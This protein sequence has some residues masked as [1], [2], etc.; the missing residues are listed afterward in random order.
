M[1]IKYH[2]NPDTMKPGVCKARSGNC[3]FKI[4]DDKHFSNIVEAREYIEKEL[5]EDNNVVSSLDKPVSK[6]ITLNNYSKIPLDVEDEE[7]ANAEVLRLESLVSEKNEDEVLETIT[8]RGLGDN[9]QKA[10][11]DRD[12]LY[13]LSKELGDKSKEVRE[14]V[15]KGTAS[16]VELRNAVRNQRDI[17]EHL[18]ALNNS[19]HQYR[20]VTARYAEAY[21]ELR[22]NRQRENGEFLTYEAET[23]GSLVADAEYE[24][25]SPEWHNQRQGGIGGSDVAK[26]MKVDEKYGQNEYNELLLKKV[27][28]NNSNDTDDFRNDY[29][30]AVG[31]G[32]AWEETIRHMY[33][34]RNPDKN[35]A[36]CKTSWEGAGAESYKHAN[37]DG[38]E[39]DEN[40]KPVGII[41]IK[42]GI[43]T[44]KWGS[45]DDGY[46]G[47]PENYRK[48]VLWYAANADLK[49]ATLVAVLDDYDYREY[50]FSMSDPRAQAEVAEMKKA[51]SEFWNTVETHKE[52][53]ANGIDNVTKASGIRKGFPK[54]LNKKDISNKVSVYTGETP[55]NVRRKL[56][57]V[58]KNV[59]RKD[60]NAV[61]AALTSFY[62]SFDPAE[63]KRPLIGIDL[64]TNSSSS[65]KGRIIETGIVSLNNDGSTKVE[66]SSLHGISDKSMRGAG[67]GLEEVHK[68]N[69]EMIKGKKPFEDPETQREILKQLKRGT[70]VAHNAS[71]EKEWL[72]VNLD[73][74]AEALDKK[75]IRI[76]DTQQLASHLMTDSK[77]NTLNSFAEDNGVAYEGAHAATTDT[78]MMMEALGN[79]RTNLHKNGKV[80]KQTV[81]EQDREK[82]L[83]N[84]ER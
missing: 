25:G 16:Y 70:L 67:A 60:P 36:F 32:N 29:N 33:A 5:S 43:H 73:G 13:A 63:R 64:E 58:L 62:G 84:I 52:E 77:S 31:R 4:D 34:D 83:R 78:K 56:D 23:I 6:N 17:N 44:D 2:V 21:S 15:R 35:V 24:S 51:T 53:L 69:S 61:Q 28:L 71:F 26:I 10:I 54:T 79:F 81:S 27:G 38:L 65:S 22:E 74:F 11:A 14:N 12:S 20:G 59:D 45:T 7:F 42:T 40:G 41:E 19:I 47:M 1:K 72:T 82:A 80:V 9:F 66:Y 49:D 68:I 3:R 48:Q 39:L 75:Q 46:A 50:K 8:S 57:T 55:Y 76:L 30:S 18:A 37:F